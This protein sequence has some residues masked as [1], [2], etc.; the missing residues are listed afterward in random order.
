M[1]SA[2]RPAPCSAPLSRAWGTAAACPGAAPAES[3]GAEAGRRGRVS[4]DRRAS[5][6]AKRLSQAVSAQ[7]ADRPR[8]A[9]L[10]GE[11]LVILRA[12]GWRHGDEATAGRIPAKGGGRVVHAATSR[13]PGGRQR[14]S[15]T[16][17]TW[18]LK[19]ARTLP[20]FSCFCCSSSLILPTGLPHSFKPPGLH[21]PLGRLAA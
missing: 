4:A 13:R 5:R 2:G 20:L 18:R 12:V 10:C 6:A 21:S 3:P 17:L 19:P 14:I 16:Y 1:G 7:R 15:P 9:R 11:K 8:G